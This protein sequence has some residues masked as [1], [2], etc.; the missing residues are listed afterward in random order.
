MKEHDSVM[1]HEN[2]FE[3]FIDPNGDNHEYYELE[4]NALGTGL[5]S[6]PAASLQGRRQGGER[7]GDSWVS[8]P[9]FIWTA[10]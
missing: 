6:A 7:L 3:F 9:R 2:D 5:G 10:P 8:S 4:I 1:F